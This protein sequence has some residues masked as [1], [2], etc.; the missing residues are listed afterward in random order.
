MVDKIRAHVDG[1][2]QEAPSTRRVR[3]AREELL[4]GCLDKYSDLTASGQTPEEAFDAVVSGIGDVDELLRTLGELDTFDP[5]TAQIQRNKRA[6]FV[7]VGVFICV[8]SIAVAAILSEYADTAAGAVMLVL[9]AVGVGVIIYGNMSTQVKFE[10]QDDTMVEDM[11][12]QFVSGTRNARMRNAVSSSMWS[13]IVIIY[14]GL[15]F[16]AG[17][18]HPG[19]IIFPIGAAVQTGISTFFSA[20]AKR[21]Y[22]YHSLLW[23]TAVV[24]YLVLSFATQRW[25]I[26]WLIFPLTVGIQQLLH[27]LQVWRSQ[28]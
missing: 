27:L 3:E 13:L 28:E 9:L 1:L 22:G 4:A 7:S 6:L 17:M 25:S 5:K 15:G 21:K 19:W 2:F 26:T 18:W 23:V 24:I 12:E 20:P 16:F 14:L 11:K 8:L 10:K